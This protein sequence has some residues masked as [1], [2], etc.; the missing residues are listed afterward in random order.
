MENAKMLKILVTG[1]SGYIGS[2][3]CEFLED[4]G[5]NVTRLNRPV[6]NLLNKKEVDNYFNNVEYDV[7]IH[8]AVVGGSRLKQED[9]TIISDN[10]EM[11]CNL[12]RHRKRYGKFIHFGSGAQYLSNTFYGL[13]KKAIETIVNKL[14]L[15]YNINIY[16]LFSDTESDTRF[17]KA[18]IK[19]ALSGEDIII[20]KNKKMDFF[21]M[22]DLLKLVEYYIAND[23]LEKNIDCSYKTSLTLLEIAN[24]IKLRCNPAVDIKIID[25]GYE[26]YSGANTSHL[27]QIIGS[28]FLPR[29]EETIDKIKLNVQGR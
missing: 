14:D 28:D 21:H 6:C 10:L 1:S 5:Y 24:I 22:K 26:E 18:N 29:L 3:L 12:L 4:K 27:N 15:F 9:E 20:H 11:F 19:R 2:S 13:S 17:I 7:L 23:T 25:S 16:G 8:T